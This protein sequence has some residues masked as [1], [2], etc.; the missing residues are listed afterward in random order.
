MRWKRWVQR[1]K[2][3]NWPR[4]LPRKYMFH[5]H[6]YSG[7][8]QNM[9]RPSWTMTQVFSRSVPG[10]GGSSSQ[11][12]HRLSV[13]VDILWVTSFRQCGGSWSPGSPSSAACSGKNFKRT[14]G[15]WDGLQNGD[16]TSKLGCAH[17]CSLLWSYPR[18]KGG[19]VL[20]SFV[21]SCIYRKGE[22]C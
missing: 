15:V 21:Q 17:F 10:M 3:N 19:P 14:R 20:L 18:Y 12:L 7:L 8:H 4:R 2:R 16:W 22:S 11:G 5:C 13:F 9:A 1:R 6:P